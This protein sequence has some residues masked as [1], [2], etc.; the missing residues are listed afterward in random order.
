MLK[1]KIIAVR[2]NVMSEV[3]R[4]VLPYVNLGF[5]IDVHYKIADSTL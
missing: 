4:L 1:S 3:I 5:T 2:K